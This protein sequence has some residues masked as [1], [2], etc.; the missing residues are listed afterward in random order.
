MRIPWKIKKAAKGLA[1]GAVSLC[2]LFAIGVTAA[3]GTTDVDD[4][5]ETAPDTGTSDKSDLVYGDAIEQYRKTDFSACW[6]WDQYTFEDEYVAFRKTFTLDSDPGTATAYVSAESKYFMW[7]NGELTVYDGSPKRGPTPYDSYY[8][9]VEV[10]GLQEGEN[11]LAFLVA[12]NG[13]S[14]DSSIDA[15]Q[16]LGEGDTQGGFLFEMEAGG[17]TIRSDSSFKVKRLTEY[18][19]RLLLGTDY[20]NYD[21]AS[22]LGERDVYYDARDSVG[23]YTSP[24]FDDSDWDS[25]TLVANPGSLPFGDLYDSLTPLIAFGEITDFEDPEGYVGTEFSEDTTVTFDLPENMQFSA[26]FE[27]EAEAGKTITYY[28]DTFQIGTTGSYSFKDTYVTAEGE[29]AYE[30][31][32]WRSGAQLILELEAG[33]MITRIGYRASGYASEN[34]G[35]FTSSDEDLN[36]LWQ[37]CENTL[38]ICMR[39]GFMDCP[40]RERGPYMGD[41]TVQMDN[42]YYS[43]DTD[44]LALIKKSVLNCVTWTGTDG[45]IPSRAPSSKPHEIPVQSLAFAGSAYRYVLYSG[46]TETGYWYYQD[47]IN[48]LGVWEM[49]SNGMPETRD[50]EW[51]WTDWGSGIDKEVIQICW[52]YY[53]LQNALDLAEILGETGDAEFLTGRME[54]IRENFD[55]LYRQDDGYRSDDTPDDRAN[56]MAVLCGLADEDDYDLVLSVLT[57]V[58]QASP[59]MEKYILEALCMMGEYETAYSRMLYRYGDMIESSDTTVWELFTR[60]EGTNNHGWSG[61]PLLIMSKY[62]AGIAP[63]EAGY[64]SYEIVPQNLFS[65]LEANVETVKGDISISYS[66]SG[67]T[68]TFTVKTIDADGTVKIPTS[69]GSS[70]SGSGFENEGVTDGYIVLSFTSAGTY[71]FTVS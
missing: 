14:S 52:Y 6:I 54:T 15:A 42:V 34:T 64:E 61:G 57:S 49:Q 51:D 4:V 23:D 19:N 47:L 13:R 55:G 38:E 18:K 60:D 24:D 29:Q 44:A 2:M 59:Y 43:L 31:Y 8:D 1:W 26:Y 58:Y 17:Q 67:G 39:D 35:S 71:T 68:T 21:Q 56:A 48:Y 12:Y 41:A 22:M 53:A 11:T 16:A 9:T 37:K 30:S 25:A 5:I 40:D 27:L 63:T 28:T 32:P 70:V 33:I 66:T 20:P 10:T 7:V 46:D 45:L 69:F 65:S 36:T 50:G 3:C 62:F